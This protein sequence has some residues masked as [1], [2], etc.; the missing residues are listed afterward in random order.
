MDL[1]AMHLKELNTVAKECAGEY[2]TVSN[3]ILQYIRFSISL[4]KFNQY[5]R[6]EVVAGKDKN[7][8]AL[9]TSS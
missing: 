5:S 9:Q 4:D 3:L 6:I 7:E 8:T 1:T 2:P